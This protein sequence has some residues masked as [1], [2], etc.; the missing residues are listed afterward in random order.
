MEEFG[1]TLHYI[2]GE[3]NTVANA[4]YLH[5]LPPVLG[6]EGREGKLKTP[7]K[8][9]VIQHNCNHTYVQTRTNI[10]K[11][12]LKP[13]NILRAEASQNGYVKLK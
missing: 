7:T 2:K 13:K 5:D 12:L 9:D 3:E 1:A 10:E 11:Y 4:L 6:T 8:Y